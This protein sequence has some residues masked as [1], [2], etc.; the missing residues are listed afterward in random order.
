V[1]LLLGEGEVGMSPLEVARARDQHAGADP[2]LVADEA[3]RTYAS[4]TGFGRALKKLA[5]AG[6]ATLALSFGTPVTPL[7]PASA[8]TV[9]G[10]VPNYFVSVYKCS[11]ITR[12][13]RYQYT[14]QSNPP[15]NP[16]VPNRYSNR[17]DWCWCWV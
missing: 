9:S 4:R 6:A 13:C 11:Y 14:Y 10:T 12:N 1:T 16:S 3:P 2:T 17:N 8:I 7:A 15:Y 5:V